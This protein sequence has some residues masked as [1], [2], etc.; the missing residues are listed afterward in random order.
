MQD[1]MPRGPRDR[2]S[3]GILYFN[4]SKNQMILQKGDIASWKIWQT[5]LNTQGYAL[6]VDGDPGPLTIATTKQWQIINGLDGDGKVGDNTI[7]AAKTKGFKGFGAVTVI[8]QKPVTI[9]AKPHLE[10]FEGDRVSQ[11]NAAMLSR[12]SPV[13]QTRGRAFI[14]AAAADGVVVQIVQSFRTFE[15]QDKLFKKRPKVTNARGGQSMHNYGLALDFAPVVNG[16]ISWDEK[17][18]ASFGKWADAAGL[19]WGGRWRKFVDLPHV[20]DVERM[21][22]KTIQELYRKGGLQAVWAHVF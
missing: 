21:P 22:L 11:I 6:D 15:E 10:I 13:L 16:K 4:R 3:W 5:F 19:E 12:V 9:P 2:L 18:Y 7:A 8:T 17:L 1:E 14:A 20:Q